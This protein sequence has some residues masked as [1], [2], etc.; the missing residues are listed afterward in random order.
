MNLIRILRSTVLMSVCAVLLTGC[1]TTNKT[2]L[3]TG[4]WP[5]TNLMLVPFSADPDIN[6]GHWQGQN[7]RGSRYDVYAYFPVFPNGTSQDPKGIGDFEV[8]YQDTLADFDRITSKIKPTFIISYGLHPD[9]VGWKIES[10]AQ[11]HGDWHNDYCE[12]TQPQTQPVF[13]SVLFAT[14]PVL[15]I[16][17]SVKQTV[18]ELRVWV[19]RE[20]GPGTFLCNYM[21]YLGMQYQAA[22]PHCE[23]AG[24]IHVGA[25][26]DAQ[27]AARANEAVLEAAL[28]R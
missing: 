24:F 21:A 28:L 6:T 5:P 12:P 3:L 23:G 9:T 19:D 16:Q 18:P 1:G 14:L 7:W 4:Y 11:W 26:V 2:V 8:D 20:Q 10:F 25:D 15:Q 22:H 17:D 13:D 27:T